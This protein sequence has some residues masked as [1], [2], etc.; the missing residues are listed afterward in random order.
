MVNQYGACCYSFQDAIGPIYHLLELRRTR[1]TC[2]YY[3][4]LLGGCLRRVGPLGPGFEQWSRCA[5][6]DVVDYEGETRGEDL[7]R[8]V[9][10]YA[11]G[12]NKSNAHWL[13]PHQSSQW[14]PIGHCDSITA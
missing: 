12:P 6:F 1:K 9:L 3:V 5:S 14:T 11:P 13:T 10:T 4:A 2:T 7:A 8:H